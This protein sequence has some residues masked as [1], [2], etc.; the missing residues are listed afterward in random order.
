L[1]LIYHFNNR[2]ATA[3]FFFMLKK[4][5]EGDKF[6]KDFWNYNINPILGYEYTPEKRNTK[7]EKLKY[8]LGNN[9]IR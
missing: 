3:P 7:K 9:E 2:G 6:P 4:L 8:G 1:K 5:K